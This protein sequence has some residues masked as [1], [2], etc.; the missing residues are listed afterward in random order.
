MRWF[1]L[2]VLAV[3]AVAVALLAHQ[4]GGG[5]AYKEDMFTEGAKVAGA[6]FVVAVFLERSLAVV[7]GLWASEPARRARARLVRGGSG[8]LAQLQEIDT[9]KE[10][11]R[12]A[13]GFVAA[14]FVSAAGVRTLEG[15]M[16]APTGGDQRTLFYGVDMLLTAG[17]LAGGSNG[18]ALIIDV[19]K[20]Q[21]EAALLRFRLAAAPEGLRAQVLEGPPDNRETRGS[22]PADSD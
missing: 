3:A 10:R 20:A 19:L 2:G 11:V 1:G 8:A 12:L 18:L 13:L 4:A 17:L 21:A 6:L 22:P 5:S 7:N 16:A 9:S 14:L 15:L